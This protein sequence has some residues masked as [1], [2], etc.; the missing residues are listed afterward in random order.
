VQFNWKWFW[1][2]IALSIPLL[3]FALLLIN[4]WAALGMILSLVNGEGFIGYWMKHGVPFM[5]AI[6]IAA[7]CSTFDIS[8]WFRLFFWIRD[9]YGHARLIYDRVEERITIDRLNGEAKWL[10]HIQHWGLGVYLRYVPQPGEYRRTGTPYAAHPRQYV[11][12]LFYG[13][14]PT[15]ILPG[16]GY[17][18]A[19]HLNPTMAFTILA[20]ANAMKMVVFGYLALHIPWQII[21][22]IIIIVVPWVRGQIERQHRKHGALKAAL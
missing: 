21:A 6:A 14:T 13:F 1:D 5:G 3:I 20:G 18:I 2:R 7:S 11:W 4:E 17:S 9:A 8:M 12:L 16:V 19:F 22:V 15:C 10:R